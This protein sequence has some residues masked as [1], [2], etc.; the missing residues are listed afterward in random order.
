M[1]QDPLYAG[2][3]L[4]RPRFELACDFPVAGQIVEQFI[5]EDVVAAIERLLGET[6]PNVCCGHQ[7]KAN[8][9]KSQEFGHRVFGVSTLTPRL[10]GAQ[11]FTQHEFGSL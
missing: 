11:T 2:G 7:W 10:Q 9:Q 8:E 4:S 6:N 1:I 5:A 3:V